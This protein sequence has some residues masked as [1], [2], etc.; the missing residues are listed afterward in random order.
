MN[1]FRRA[2]TLIELLV[3]IA[4]IAVLIGLLLPAVQKV[5][6]AAARTTCANNVKQLV[7]ATHNFASANADQLPSVQYQLMPGVYGS[8]MVALMPYLEQNNLYD[9]YFTPGN[10]GTASAPTATNATVIKQPFL[11][12]SDYTC[13]TGVAQSGWAGTSYAANALIFSVPGWFDESVTTEA[14]YAIDTV[15]DGT[16]NTIGFTE[17]MVEAE[18]NSSGVGISNNRDLYCAP[19]PYGNAN[20]NYPVFGI[21]QSTYPDYFS[22]AYWWFGSGSFQF[23]PKNGGDR[24][25]SNSG[26]TVAIQVGM[27]DGSVRI[28]TPNTSVLTYWLAAIPNDGSPPA[29]DWN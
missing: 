16:S 12:P 3:V 24:W 7:L 22:T 1:H 25:G 5:R 13:P 9:Q 27:M 23:Q 29:S 26:H 17:R 28:V 21:Y 2:F 6:E 18:I 4:I 15:P 19:E 14:R 11:C 8:V 10:M 20:Y